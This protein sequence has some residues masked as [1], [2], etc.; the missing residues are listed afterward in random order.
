MCYNKNMRKFILLLA[1]LF[2]F[3]A[4]P[5]SAASD[6]SLYFK[7]AIFDYYLERTESGSTMKVKETLKAVFSETSTSHGITRAIPFSNQNGQNIT[8]D[9]LNLTVTR[10]GISE[11]VAKT[12][13]R[14]GYF[15]VNVGSKS[16]TVQ[17]EQT[18]V[19]EYEFK[20]VITEYDANGKLTTENGI[21]QELYWDTNGTGWANRFDS[22]TANV[23]FAGD[24]KAKTPAYCYTGYQGSSTRYC[25]V[26]KT[27][28]GFTF[29]TTRPLGSYENMTFDIEFPAGTFKIPISYNYTLVIFTVAAGAF[30]LFSIL[31]AV[32]NYRKYAKEKYLY[33]K[34]LLVA[35]QYLPPK[36]L[37][38]AEASLIY[39]EPSEPT[40][41]ATLLE[42]AIK[43][44]VQL[45]SEK[46]TSKILGKEKTVW[47]VKILNLDGLTSPEEKVLRI[48]T[49]GTMPKV[50]EIVEIKKHTATSSLASLSRGYSS[51]ACA[52]LRNKKLFESKVIDSTRTLRPSAES[53]FS[54][55]LLIMLIFGSLLFTVFSID[56]DSPIL[57]YGRV[58]G[59]DH[60]LAIIWGIT[61]L[62]LIIVLSFHNKTRKYSARTLAGLD[63]SNYL[64][65]LRL[66]IEM[67]E[68]ERLEFNQ[69]TKNAPKDEKGMV[70]LY[71]K[72]LP[73]ACMFG[74]EES[75]LKEIQK[76]YENLN[77]SPDWYDGTDILTYSILSSMM[78]TTSSSIAESTAWHSSSSSS[79]FSGGGGGG[80]SGGGGGG[81]GGGSW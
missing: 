36:D 46:T 40:E 53:S 2:L 21:S 26:E 70:K 5:V 41:T 10:N 42:L 49:G 18:Y 9:N 11:P 1:S 7:D 79:G 66:Y 14:D 60:L 12:E 81:G 29:K 22:V 17:G 44:K 74:Q 56:D 64:E 19:L 72:L 63:T 48:L 13:K 67:A 55:I 47:K 78:H 33:A 62:T 75:W 54:I 61:I 8:I 69:S 24:Y 59:K 52:M 32:K 16:K 3:N 45:A 27:K 43:H 6:P 15:Q 30:G 51:S 25:T 39:L 68:K 31:L 28:D 34:N 37:T 58:V 77:Y 73:Y 23:H 80:F 38:I 76:Y 4:T 57:S 50:G 20:N 65:G 71:E 35:P